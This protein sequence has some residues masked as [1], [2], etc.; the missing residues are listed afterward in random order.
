M[1]DC[2]HR[3]LLPTPSIVNSHKHS[4]FV[5]KIRHVFIYPE[6]GTFC[7]LFVAIQ[8]NH[9]MLGCLLQT[10]FINPSKVMINRFFWCKT[11]SAWGNLV[12]HPNLLNRRILHYLF[13]FIFPKKELTIHKELS[14]EMLMLAEDV[15]VPCVE[16]SVN[17]DSGWIL[18]A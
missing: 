6:F 11:T 5:P 15:H 8:R 2:C 13:Y 3:W 16:A 14:V 10:K 18:W 12:H 17:K 1:D 4:I 9:G 7:E